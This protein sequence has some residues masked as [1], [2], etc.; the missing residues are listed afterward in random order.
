MKDIPLDYLEERIRE[1]IRVLEGCN[2]TT[3]MDAT[4][5]STR[6]YGR[7][8]TSRLCS[9]KVKRKFVKVHLTLDLE[10]KIILIG[11]SA[12]GWKGD[13]AFGLRMLRKVKG[14]MRRNKV[15]IERYWEILDKH[16]GRWQPSLVR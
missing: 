5:L 2:L 16:Q 6:Q 13:H 12:K 3:L 14:G 8:K 7:W 1:S 15:N 11:L 4:R 9:K 10:R